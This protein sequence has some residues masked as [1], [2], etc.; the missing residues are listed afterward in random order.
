MQW[1]FAIDCRKF[2]IEMCGADLSETSLQWH[3]GTRADPPML[4]L[5][6]I[7]IGVYLLQP[8]SQCKVQKLRRTL[9]E[10]R[11]QRC[12]WG[13][14]LRRCW[15]WDA[16]AYSGLGHWAAGTASLKTAGEGTLY[17]TGDFLLLK[18]W[19][20]LW[21]YFTPPP[22]TC[23]LCWYC[24]NGLSRRAL[25][26]SLP[27]VR[28][29]QISSGLEQNFVLS[30]FVQILKLSVILNLFLNICIYLLFK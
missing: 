2:E 27:S 12:S 22:I 5:V 11:G 14:Q 15:Y 9:P 6:W 7:L 13:P 3:I 20:L 24:F 4:P 16:A 30:K 19:I 29:E 8:K 25:Y 18:L 1:I 26:S 17:P 28:Y 23:L 21:C 10:P